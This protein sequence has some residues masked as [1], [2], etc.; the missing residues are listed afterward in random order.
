MKH[1]NVALFIPNNGCKNE[2]SFCN[3]RSIV[4]Q[5]YQPT[6]ED[7]VKAIKVA[8][9]SL[10]ANTK[11]AEIAFF[12][13]SFTAIDR[14]YM[15]ELLNAAYPFIKNGEFKGIRLSTRPDYIDEK[16]LAILKKFG[17]TSIELGAQSM[18]DEVL[19][20]NNRGH[21]RQDVIDASNLIKNT[22]F[23]LG[24][25]MMTGLYKT[26]KERDIK[27]AEDFISLKPDTVR[28]YPTVVIKGTKLQELYDSGEYI[29]FDVEQSVILCTKLLQLFN[30]NGI[31]VIR[32][33]LHASEQL[34][35]DYVA[36][37][38]HPAF[39][40]LCESRLMLDKVKDILSK[41]EY[42]TNIEISVNDKCVSKM[43]GQKKTNIEL[44]NQI[45]YSAIIK[46]DKSLNNDEIKIINC[47]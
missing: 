39:K 3:Q 26:T 38:Y 16:I 21:S 24:L 43:I 14:N 29:P 19:K 23:S 35:K 32:M 1:S 22:G 7:V 31:K 13:G 36:G 27:T 5:A 28:I 25:Q 9:D 40:E 37:A 34:R 8:K 10:K 17:V 20:A 42:D 12:G 45:G 46:A 2:C 15:I 6:G 30:K 47:R 33:G 41:D 18:N 11:D 44:L 4:G